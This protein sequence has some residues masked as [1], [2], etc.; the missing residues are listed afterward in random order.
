MANRKV[1]IGLVA[2]LAI[3]GAA[4][5]LFGYDTILMGEAKVRRQRFFGRVVK[6]TIDGPRSDEAWQY[7]WRNPAVHHGLP[8]VVRYDRN[9]DGYMETVSRPLNANDLGTTAEFEVDTNR[10][11]A[12]DHVFIDAFASGAGLARVDALLGVAGQKRT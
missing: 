6:L 9:G 10:D 8:S 7:S 1:I 4:W 12:A 11:G 3:L 5:L 2:C